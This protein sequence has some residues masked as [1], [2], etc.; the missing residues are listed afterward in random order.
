MPAY[1]VVEIEVLDAERYED[2]K[3]M[4]P[5]SL[6]AYGGKF[7]VRGGAVETLEGDWSPK[8]FVIVEFPSVERAKEWWASAEYAEAKALRQA[9]A[10]TQMIVVGGV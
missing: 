2:Y 4:V 6:A 10:R 7:L 9:T 8:R 1:V 5:P 3:R